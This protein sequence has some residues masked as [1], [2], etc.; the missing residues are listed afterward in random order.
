MEMHETDRNFLNAA[1]VCGTVIIIALVAIFGEAINSDGN[2]DDGI[3]YI[4]Y[5]KCY[6]S[7]STE[8]DTLYMQLGNKLCT[9]IDPD[10]QK[11]IT[12]EEFTRLNN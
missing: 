11:P 9:I 4:G 3:Q 7:R 6:F 2:S 5:D 12:S 8:D 1:I 10:T